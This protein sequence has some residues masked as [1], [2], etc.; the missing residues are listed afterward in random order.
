MDG[1]ADE[2]L[3]AAAR[4]LKGHQRRVFQGRVCVALCQGS[5]RLAEARFGWG[6]ESV[7]KGLLELE[8]H[9]LQPAANTGARRGRPSSEE[10][11]PQL[12]VDICLIVEP[13]THSDPELKTE[14]LYTNR[15]AAE[16]RES[17]LAKGYKCRAV[18]CV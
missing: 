14:R 4:A 17:L 11:N 16:V 6:R 3:L 15:S 2:L 5:P 10:K 12:A 9:Q 18:R 8:G 13:H 1:V 7:A